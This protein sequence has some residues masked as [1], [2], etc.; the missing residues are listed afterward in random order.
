MLIGLTGTLGSG[1]GTVAQYL[2]KKHNF[3]YLSV[4]AFF[5]AEVVREGKMVNR[6]NIAEM[7]HKIRAEHGPL[8]PLEQLLNNSPHAKNIVVES[9]RTLNEANYLKSH[10]DALWAVDADINIR[11]K[12]VVARAGELDNISIDEF[13]KQD[14]AELHSDDPNKPNIAG[15]KTIASHVFDA[16]GTKE[17]LF[18]Q[19]E[20]VL[21]EALKAP[22]K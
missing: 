22:Q 17:E 15:L 3:L 19:V 9:I 21:T 7:A 8:Y 11:Y 12:R 5:A 6:A 1:K 18:A 20:K 14:E 13:K 10:G 2:A 4:R 16:G